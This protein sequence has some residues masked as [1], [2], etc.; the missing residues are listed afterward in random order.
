MEPKIEYMRSTA[1]GAVAA[2]V[3]ARISSG[4]TIFL[5]P[6]MVSTQALIFSSVGSA[7]KSNR[8][9]EP[10]L[11]SGVNR[12]AARPPGPMSAILRTRSG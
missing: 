4:E 3:R 9:R 5:L 1:P 10:S 6:T 12:G 7:R 8:R 2:S 11:G